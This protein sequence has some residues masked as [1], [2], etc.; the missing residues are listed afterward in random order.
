LLA[1]EAH[2]LSTLQ[3]ARPA[4]HTDMIPLAQLE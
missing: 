2:Y 3:A 4:A 1:L